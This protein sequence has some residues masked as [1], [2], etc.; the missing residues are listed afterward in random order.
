MTQILPSLTISY[1]LM[2]GGRASRIG[3]RD[4]KATL[5]TRETDNQILA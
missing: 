1:G 3:L 4:Y 5:K 2:N